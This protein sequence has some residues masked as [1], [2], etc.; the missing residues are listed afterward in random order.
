MI[1]RRNIIY[2]AIILGLA[3][4]TY[5]VFANFFL[6]DDSLANSSIKTVKFIY[7]VKNTD[8][9]VVKKALFSAYLPIS[10][11]ES[12]ASRE[13][14]ENKGASLRASDEGNRV[15][16]ISLG[17]IPPFGIKKVVLPVEIET[18]YPRQ[19]SKLLDKASFLQHEKFVEV[20]SADIQ[21]KSADL[22]GSTDLDTA[23]NIYSWVVKNIKEAGYTSQDKG[24]LYA[25]KQ[26]KGDCTEYMY[27]TVALARAAGIPARGVAGYVYKHST[28]AKSP[29]YHNWAELYFNGRWNVVDPQKRHFLS[30]SRDY[31][32]M[33]LLSDKTLNLSGSSHRFTTANESLKIT[34]L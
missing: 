5:F 31:I 16:D 9:S 26:K 3:T 12:Q 8:S 1:R 30:D 23:T 24:A 17:V 7:E 27:V 19:R 33:R 10:N 34:M 28:I 20:D 14:L 21:Q 2:L 29:D 4:I 18:Y 13:L 32:T 22:K 25:M 11:I 15:I 6:K